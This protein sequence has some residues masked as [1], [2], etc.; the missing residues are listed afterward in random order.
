MSVVNEISCFEKSKGCEGVLDFEKAFALQTG[1]FSSTTVY[2]C[3]ICGR[4]C[5][6]H[7]TDEPRAIGMARRSGE[8]VYLVNGILECKA[9]DSEE[10]EEL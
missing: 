2:P 6:V 5:S 1:C 8:A 10:T 4:V 7:G 3:T 9:V